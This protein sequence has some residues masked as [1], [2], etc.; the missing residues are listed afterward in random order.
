[1]NNYKIKVILILLVIFGNISNIC[2]SINTDS[3][4]QLLDNSNNNKTKFEL[5][6]QLSNHYATNKYDSAII[7]CNKAIDI[8]KQLNKPQ[9]ILAIKTK[10]N[11]MFRKGELNSALLLYNSAVNIFDTDTVNIELAKIYNNIGLLNF[12]LGNLNNAIL[13]LKKASITYN[14][15][16]N[17]LLTTGPLINMGLIYYRTAD[18]KKAEE[19]FNVALEI[20]EKFNKTDITS[21]ILVNFGAVYKEWGKFSS[22]INAYNKAINNFILLND[23]YRLSIAYYNKGLIYE[24]LSNYNKAI[25]EIIKSLELKKQICAK[26]KI[27]VSL[28]KIGDI[29]CQWN[30]YDLALNYYVDALILAK[31]TGNK[32]DIANSLSGM[33]QVYFETKIFPK[34][35]DYYS[36]ALKIYTKLNSKNEIAKI[37]NEIGNIYCN[38]LNQLSKANEYFEISEK[39]FKE[40][41]SNSGLADLYLNMANCLIL[42]K[43]YFDAIKH[44]NNSIKLSPTN[45]FKLYN[46]YLLLADTYSAI[47]NYKNATYAYKKAILY[48]DSLF[49]KK[50]NMQ[51]AKFNTQYKVEKKEQEIKNLL[52]Q[53]E[54]NVLLLNKKKKMQILFI[55]LAVLSLTISMMVLFFYKKLQ[56]INK[57]LLQKQIKIEAQKQDLE[58][59]NSELIILNKKAEKLSKY[60]NNFLA[61]ISHEIRTPLNAISGYAKLLSNS[62][63]NKNNKYYVS[64]VLQASDNMMIIVNDLLDFS[65]IEAGKLFLEKTSFNPIKVITQSISTLKFRAEEKNINLEI[66]LDPFIPKNLI[67]DP[68]R[69]S[70]ILINLISNAIKFSNNGQAVII[71][72][73]C[74]KNNNI[75]SMHFNIIDTG[76]GIP[77]S[78]LESIFD[79]FTQMHNDASRLFN[80]TGLGLSIVKRLIELQNGTISVKSKINKGS[81]FSFT[82]NYTIDNKKETKPTKNNKETYNKNNTINR[83]INV[84]L[85]EDNLINQELAKDTMLSWNEPIIVDIAENGKEAILAVQ[86]KNYDIILMDIQMPVMNGHEATQYIRNSLPEPKC[87]IPIVGMSAHAL[88]VEKEQALKNGMNEYIIKPFNPDEL[89]QK[90]YSFVL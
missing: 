82:I 67:G 56:T 47:N 2:A 72:V 49:S 65:K 5:L 11:I 13:Y 53:T 22:A 20:A 15:L 16:N 27:P 90:I 26:N 52:K 84:L 51:L 61:N 70:Q 44:I 50:L 89:K 55:L 42:Q 38:K 8:S 19:N 1:M 54:I 77:E 31:E 18:Y 45:N 40:I 81:T 12:N 68:Y 30:K 10:G 76:F 41:K 57:Q 37:N 3:I 88:P 63:V 46:N 21:N 59:K 66:H 23:K 9:K 17:K 24:E 73:E 14:T 36:E 78:K 60:K 75:C 32:F 28:N 71:E 29:Y 4:I 87:N 34:S 85:V 7:F 62:E 58:D 35:L 83:T 74:K 6:I 69:L 86:K 64:Q 43:R 39:I 80:G 33:G 48:K 25:D 79:S